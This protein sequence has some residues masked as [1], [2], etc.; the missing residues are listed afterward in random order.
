MDN[1]TVGELLAQIKTS[2]SSVVVREDDA[3][4]DV[5]E[6]MIE[7]RDDRTVYV[8][9]R[10]DRFLGVLSLG[11]L[12]RHHLADGVY[13]QKTMNPATHI[14]KFLTQETAGDLM[15]RQ[16]VVCR[17]NEKVEA[18]VRRMARPVLIKV[19]PVLDEEGHV[20]GSLD[21]LDVI[22]CRNRSKTR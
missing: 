15:R 21:L 10:D 19:I 13:D 14:L 8:V 17:P 5:I 9:D 18:V 2:S 16:C 20:I 3:L 1:M 4:D 22:A 11:D 6:K 7:A 12:V